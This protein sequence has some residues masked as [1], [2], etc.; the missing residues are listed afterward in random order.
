V[1]EAI[2]AKFAAELV[3]YS[4]HAVD[5]SIL[6]HI[7]VA[8]VHAAVLTGEII[9]DYPQDKYGPSCLV[10]GFARDGRPLHVHCTHPW[11]ERLKVFILYWP[12]P[13]LWVDS[14]TRRQRHDL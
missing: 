14:R 8:D 11:R 13:S 6:R 2:R 5:E 12:D 1:I 9:E 4:Q 3:D 10:L 7:P